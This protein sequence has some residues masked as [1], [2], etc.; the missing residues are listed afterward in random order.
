MTPFLGE[1]I[2]TAILIVLGNGTVAN[3]ILNQTKG[4]NSGWITITMGWGMAVF[5]AVFCVSEFSGAHINPAVTIGLA[6]AGMF[7]WSQ[8]PTYIVAQMIG[9]ATGSF[10]VWLSYRDHFN[11]TSDPDILLSVH[12]TMP[13]IR[14]YPNNLLT[15][16]I[17]TFILLLGVFY[18]ISPGFIGSDGQLLEVV[19]IDG[20]EIGFGLGA[21]AALPVGLLVLGIGIAL[22]GPTGYA[23]NPA[24][25]LGPRIMHALLPIRGK[26]DSDL[27]YAWVPV[28]GPLLGAVAAALLYLAL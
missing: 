14:N 21:L 15:E 22:G 17:G 23:I 11:A 28:V 7:E 9:A 10:L 2:G 27:P 1:L 6:T 25:D 12:S 26:R 19:M 3:V 16:A 8:V 13:A 18:I 20:E 24:R 5:I 4:H